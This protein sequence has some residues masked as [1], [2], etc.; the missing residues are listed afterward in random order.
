MRVGPARRGVQ[1]EERCRWRR[2]GDAQEGHDR[3]REQRKQVRGAP[4]V[5]C[6]GVW[7]LKNHK[8]INRLWGDGDEGEPVRADGADGRCTFWSRGGV[9]LLAAE[10]GRT[11]EAGQGQ[12]EGR[13][14]G[15]RGR[16]FEA[17]RRLR[18]F[19]M[20]GWSRSAATSASS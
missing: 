6:R 11:R 16:V 3:G 10:R 18:S 14:V 5:R 7:K 17:G 2:G 19:L 9:L 1:R 20:Q 15:P 4:P 13:A 12:P 8:E